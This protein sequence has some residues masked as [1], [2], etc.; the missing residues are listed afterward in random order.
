MAVSIKTELVRVRV[1]SEFEL[2][3][4][5]VKVVARAP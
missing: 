4:S 3:N 5:G 1:R 2:V